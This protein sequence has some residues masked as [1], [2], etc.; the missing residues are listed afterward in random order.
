[1]TRFPQELDLQRTPQF[2]FETGS[3]MLT[4]FSALFIVTALLT[5]AMIYATGAMSIL[6]GVALVA[7]GALA[8]LGIGLLYWS[9]KL[10]RM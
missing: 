9:S 2:L 6:A 10:E 1:M 5:T 4:V 7:F 8:L 3:L